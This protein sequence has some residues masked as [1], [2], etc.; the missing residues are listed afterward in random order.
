MRESHNCPRTFETHFR[1]TGC[2]GDHGSLTL[3]FVRGR[4]GIANWQDSQIEVNEI[5]VANHHGHPVLQLA[6]VSYF[7]GRALFQYRGTYRGFVG[8]GHRQVG[9]GG[10]GR[11]ELRLPANKLH[12]YM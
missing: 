10:F 12:L 1:C 2:E 5:L 6:W 8:D 3:D 11:D 4:D 9:E 7:E